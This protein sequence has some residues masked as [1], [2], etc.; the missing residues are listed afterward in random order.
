[1][2]SSRLVL[3]SA[4]VGLLISS[5]ASS[6]GSPPYT[7]HRQTDAMTYNVY[8]GADLTPII[9]AQTI[10][11]L[12]I[13]T[14]TEWMQVQASDIPGRAAKIADEIA[15]N[16]PALVGLQEVA[17]WSVGP[18]PTDT[19]VQYDFLDLILARLSA[20]GAHYSPVAVQPDIDATAPMFDAN[21]NI[22]F[23]R[24]LDRDVM[25][26]RTD[27]P[28]S[29]LKISNVQSATYSTL[30]VV[31]SPLGPI[32]V[33]RSYIA[34]D[35]KV[36][37]KNFRFITTHLE[38]FNS[39]INAAQGQELIDGPANTVLP[40]VAVGDYNSSANGGPDTTPTYAALL[41]AGFEDAWEVLNPND[42]GNTCC[43]APDLGNAISALYERIDLVMVRGGMDPAASSVINTEGSVQPFWPS[44]HAGVAAT[45]RVPTRASR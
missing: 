35:A 39:D 16:A 12:L 37:G 26:A 13:A 32:T 31:P 14:T 34:A 5:G 11:E 10:P 40:V 15:A 44:D 4:F 41:A 45:I 9:Q 25:L 19:Q 2:K 43:Q 20:D 30:L 29:K 1:M 33:P 8:F 3:L 36:R 22:V 21:S 28:A 38:T 24:I 27:M 23:V 18:A 17:Q 7:P 42:P 6:A